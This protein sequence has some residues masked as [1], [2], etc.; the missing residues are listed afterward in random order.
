MER[1]TT[2][3]RVS[4]D[5][6]LPPGDNS[7][8][9]NTGY[10]EDDEEVSQPPKKHKGVGMPQA[11]Q[12]NQDREPL[13]PKGPVKKKSKGKTLIAIVAVL[14]VCIGGGFFGIK[15]FNQFIKPKLESDV[16]QQQQ[17]QNNGQSIDTNGQQNPTGDE[18][19]LT[20]G[21]VGTLT[22]GAPNNNTLTPGLT[23]L[24]NDSTMT[25][26]ADVEKDT[27]VTDLRGIS[28]IPNYTVQEIQTVTDMVNYTKHRAITADGMELL[29][30]EVTY[31]EKEYKVTVPF[32]IFKELDPS[33]ITVVDMEVL[34]LANGS[35]IIS[36][37]KVREDYKNKLEQGLR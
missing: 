28:V 16:T 19:T 5:D 1:Q 9:R 24:Q 4:V 15:L 18:G 36:H 37:M 27:M 17:Q 26:G 29:W 35:Q 20:P 31:K 30:L 23:D 6:F 22:P 10:R 13:K 32:K 7:L 11:P 8:N 12:N 2:K 21:D 3:R 33:G 14:V 25:N 34:N